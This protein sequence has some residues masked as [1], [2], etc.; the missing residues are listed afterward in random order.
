MV[1]FIIP[2][3]LDLSS[4][5]N[6]ER[7]LTFFDWFGRMIMALPISGKRLV[8][9]AFDRGRFLSPDLRKGGLHMSTSE[10]LQLCLVII[11]ICSL[12]VQIYKKK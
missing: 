3:T 5:R 6:V 7:G 11:G 12:F 1:I 10:V 2:D 9:L 8:P 4:V